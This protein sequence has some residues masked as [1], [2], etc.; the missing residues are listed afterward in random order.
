MTR[1]VPFDA[2]SDPV[3]PKQ[4]RSKLGRTIPLAVR[5]QVKDRSHGRC[6]HCGLPG[7][8]QLHHRKRRS[9]GGRHTPENLLNV[10]V[11]CHNLIHANPEKA[12]AMGW[13]VRGWADPANVPAIFEQAS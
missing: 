2:Q 8:V 11:E 7:A 12:Y 1:I 5:Q 4:G 9:Q 6:E 10:R 13:L 3:L